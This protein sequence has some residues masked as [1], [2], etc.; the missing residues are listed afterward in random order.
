MANE[1]R[2]HKIQLEKDSDSPVVL[3]MGAD[4]AGKFDGNCLWMDN[5]GQEKC[6]ED[7]GIDP[8]EK[9]TEE[10]RNRAVSVHFKNNVSFDGTRYEVRLP[11]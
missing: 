5:N 7:Y 4:K 2:N 10:E 6:V 9:L 8:A 11:W 3:V 1:L